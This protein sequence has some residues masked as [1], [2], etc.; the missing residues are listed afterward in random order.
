MLKRDVAYFVLNL[1]G[2]AVCFYSL[3]VENSKAIDKD[4]VAMCDLSF[5]ASCSKAVTS[6]Y[7]FFLMHIFTQ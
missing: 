4:Y 7:V 2:I 3:H 6:E 1:L 5:K